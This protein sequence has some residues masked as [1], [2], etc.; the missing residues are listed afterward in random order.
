MFSKVTIFAA[1]IAGSAAFQTYVDNI[2]NGKLIGNDGYELGHPDPND[3]ANKTQFALDYKADP[4]WAVLCELDSDGD[5][6]KNGAELGDDNC[7]GIPERTTGLTNPGFRDAPAPAPVAPTIAPTIAPTVAPT[8]APTA[9]P[10]AAPTNP[11]ITPTTPTATTTVTAPTTTTTT[12][13]ATAPLLCESR[14]G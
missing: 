9:A 6:V 11:V 1:I 7:D 2:P 8:I 13:T 4:T 14:Y 3:T 5:G 10:T 12:A